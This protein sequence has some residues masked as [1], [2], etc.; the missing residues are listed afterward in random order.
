MKPL[1]L[2]VG[3]LGRGEC[4]LSLE[5]GLLVMNS[6]E[7]LKGDLDDGG[8]GELERGGCPATS[9]VA[10]ARLGFGVPKPGEFSLAVP[11][12]LSTATL[13]AILN[14]DMDDDGVGEVM[15]DDFSAP[16][17]LPGK[18]LVGDTEYDDWVLGPGLAEAKP[19]ETKLATASNGDMASSALL[20]TLGLPEAIPAPTRLAASCHVAPARELDRD[21]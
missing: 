11:I 4:T 18:D 5:Q 10:I 17:N 14:G 1:K 15:R 19:A 6:A 2:G 8:V 16:G 13:D 21:V 20:L 12:G 7:P 9:K 3:E